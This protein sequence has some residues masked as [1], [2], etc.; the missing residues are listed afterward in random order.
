MRYAVPSQ[1]S[2]MDDPRLRPRDRGRTAEEREIINDKRRSTP[3]PMNMGIGEKLSAPFL[4]GK[5]ERASRTARSSS[6][7]G[8]LRWKDLDGPDLWRS[9]G[10]NTEEDER[11]EFK[12]RERGRDGMG[13]RDGGGSGRSDRER[14]AGLSDRRRERDRDRDRDRDRRYGSPLR[15]VDGRR[16]PGN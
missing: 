15:G 1:Q 10:G 2:P 16:Y 14:E 7:N 13:S 8:N 11:A 6:R 5:R 9:S 3:I 12:R 4:L